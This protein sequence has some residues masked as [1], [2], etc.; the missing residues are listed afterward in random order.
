MKHCIIGLTAFFLL[1]RSSQLAAQQ[2]D[3]PVSLEFAPVKFSPFGGNTRAPDQQEVRDRVELEGKWI[4]RFV[5][6]DGQPNAAQIGQ[7]M[8]DIITIKKDGN[9][10]GFG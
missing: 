10:L 8:G 1:L 7:Q 6:R 5:K 2:L 4:V 9:R 3:P